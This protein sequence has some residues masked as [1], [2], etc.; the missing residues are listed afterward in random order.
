MTWRGIAPLAHLHD[1]FYVIRLTI[2]LFRPIADRLLQ[3]S[4]LPKGSLTIPL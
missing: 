1:C 4:T 3:S 2:R